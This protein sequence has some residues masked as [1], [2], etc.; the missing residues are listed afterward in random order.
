LT[1]FLDTSYFPILFFHFSYLFCILSTYIAS[2]L[3]IS[4]IQYRQY[5][6]NASDIFIFMSYK[7]CC[8]SDFPL[9]SLCPFEEMAFYFFHEN[10]V[11]QGS[12]FQL[13]LSNEILCL[14]VG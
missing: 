11:K 5:F 8:S 13:W 3:I 9:P 4:S 2:K 14:L 1:T 12:R 6:K 10:S 7:Y